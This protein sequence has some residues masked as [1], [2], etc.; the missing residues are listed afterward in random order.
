MTEDQMEQVEQNGTV[1]GG[2]SRIVRATR[3]APPSY[4]VVAAWLIVSMGSLVLSWYVVSE[5]HAVLR[6]C[7]GV[8][9]ATNEPP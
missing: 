8:A 5:S 6:Q 7:I 2:V 4:W 3:D 9:V 1:A